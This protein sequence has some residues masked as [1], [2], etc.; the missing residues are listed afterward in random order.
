MSSLIESKFNTKT[1][2][3]N[4]NLDLLGDL[5]GLLYDWLSCDDPLDLNTLWN[6]AP[7][8]EVI[9][10]ACLD[11]GYYHVLEGLGGYKE[12][13]QT[14]PFFIYSVYRFYGKNWELN[15]ARFGY[16]FGCGFMFYQESNSFDHWFARS[17]K[18][19]V[20]IVGQRLYTNYVV[21]YQLLIWEI[22]D[23]RYP[24]NSK[25]GY[26]I[27]QR[28]MDYVG[29]YRQCTPPHEHC[30]RRCLNLEALKG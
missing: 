28:Q 8:F 27:L 26:K 1:K 16:L 24:L 12:W 25:E 5:R 23:Q 10:D 11:Q 2:T 13:E 17:T 20:H 3:N 18:M 7:K 29:K 4:A 30:I 19:D 21:T 14:I 6:F 9:L 15:T 22:S